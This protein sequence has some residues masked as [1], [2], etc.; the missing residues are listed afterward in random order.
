MK[1]KGFGH[2]KTRLFTIKTSKNVGL[3]GPWQSYIG[4]ITNHDNDLY[5]PNRCQ[6]DVKKQGFVARGWRNL[7][8][9]WSDPPS[10][11]EQSE[12]PNVKARDFL[13]AVT[14]DLP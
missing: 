5:E 8:K 7:V 2:L 6:W 9:P 3:G 13:S 11:L 4:I 12:W 10:T 14:K 1:N